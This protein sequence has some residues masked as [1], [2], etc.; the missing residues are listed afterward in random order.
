MTP[1]VT[2]YNR[3][4]RGHPTFSGRFFRLPRIVILYADLT[5]FLWK[6]PKMRTFQKINFVNTV[7]NPCKIFFHPV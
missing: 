2:A 5:A 6:L 7:K 4:A 1:S 3:T